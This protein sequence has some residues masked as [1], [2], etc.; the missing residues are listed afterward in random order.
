MAPSI[1][2]NNVE[3]ECCVPSM[4][5]G[6]GDGRNCSRKRRTSDQPD[7]V[8]VGTVS[9]CL[10]SGRL[11]VVADSET[12]GRRVELTAVRVLLLQPASGPAASRRPSSSPK[13]PVSALSARCRTIP[14]NGASI[15]RSRS[16]AC[17]SC[18][19]R[20][21]RAAVTR[22]TP[23]TAGAGR[24]RRSRAGAEACRRAPGV[25]GLQRRQH[26]V[27]RARTREELGRV[28]RDR[29]GGQHEQAGRRRERA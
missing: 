9:R 17:R 1:R 28:G 16:N 23:P 7:T 14:S 21:T 26:L 5:T 2:C 8:A 24:R 27:T 3:P 10:P 15:W 11:G 18:L 29:A 12:A 6:V 22:S 4:N 13:P 25:V 20:V 19:R